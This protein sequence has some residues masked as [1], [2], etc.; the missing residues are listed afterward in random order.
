MKFQAINDTATDLANTSPWLIGKTVYAMNLTAGSLV[1]Q[2]SS[3]N[4]VADAYAT[5]A[6]CGA[7]TST[8]AVQPVVLERYVKVSTAATLW[9]VTSF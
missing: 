7:S 9:L 1:V 4:G 2:T 5:A 8:T 3:D 6:T